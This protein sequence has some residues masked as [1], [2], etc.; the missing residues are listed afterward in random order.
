MLR[1]SALLFLLLFSSHAYAE[2]VN[3]DFSLKNF[4]DD[5]YDA[6]R[7]ANN[8]K[9]VLNEERYRSMT[10][11]FAPKDQPDNSF[12][13]RKGKVITIPKKNL[14][15]SLKRNKKLDTLKAKVSPTK[16]KP[17]IVN[18]DNDNSQ[19]NNLSGGKYIPPPLLATQSNSV[20][21]NDFLSKKSFGIKRNTWLEMKLSRTV[22]SADTGTVELVLLAPFI[23]DDDLLP[24]KT[25]FE[26]T[27]AFNS[28]NKRLN[29]SIKKGIL[30]DGTEFDVSAT[31]YDL[32]GRNGLAGELIRDKDSEVKD[33]V[34]QGVVEM[35]RSAI[36]TVAD[37]SIVGSGVNTTT[38]AMLDTESQYRPKKSTAIIITN[39]QSIKVKIDKAF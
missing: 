8:N 23:G 20:T 2:K 10:N 26:A 6:E 27:P 13:N 18:N 35:G 7:R 4:K 14:S 39:P 34:G 37:G 17:L 1:G 24:A 15:L 29:L 36:N 9:N 19:L 30:P 38:Q 12:D 11:G 3:N 25:V 31:A 33:A 22:S 16:N 32:S 28:G 21:H 5:V